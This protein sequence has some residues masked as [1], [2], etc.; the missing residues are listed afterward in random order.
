M[1][2][3]FLA[4][5]RGEGRRRLKSNSDTTFGARMRIW[6]TEPHSG[7]T[8]M[9]R[10]PSY[11]N[12]SF[13]ARGAAL[14]WLAAALSIMTACVSPKYKRADNRTPPIQPLNVKFPSS[15]LDT[16]LY[17]VISDGGPGSWKREAFWDEY[18]VTMHNDGEGA[19]TI[20]VATV[21]DYAGAVRAAGTDPW[22]L[23][24]ESKTLEKRYREAGISFARIAAPR[25]LV[26][27]AEPGVMAS[28]GIG[29]SGAA[30]A[31]TVTAV[32]LPVYG[33]AVFGINMHNKAAIK[34]EF[35]RRRIPL[36]LTLDPGETRTG[37]FFFPMVPN[38]QSLTLRWSG[39]VG[40]G[41][42]SL[43]LH[44]LEGLHVKGNPQ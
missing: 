27:A 14:F 26:S 7:D 29:A 10:S 35:N 17:T 30:A 41:D 34:K 6:A 44:F 15:M 43:E 1:G 4:R 23:E 32:A 33:A 8:D 40:E 21:T 31:A 38:P 24:R 13:A 16:S 28:A 5:G 42:T 37:S 19:L 25:V 11:A 36:P 2:R 3:R 20:A 22:A 39:S 9:T 18:V 12:R